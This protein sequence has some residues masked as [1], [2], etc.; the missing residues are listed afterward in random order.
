MS[1]SMVE[2]ELFVAPNKVPR[3]PLPVFHFDHCLIFAEKLRVS[4]M[5]IDETPVLRQKG[6]TI[7]HESTHD[8]TVISFAEHLQPTQ[9]SIRRCASLFLSTTITCA[10]PVARDRFPF[11]RIIPS[12]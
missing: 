9:S 1:G 6:G 2:L 10:R 8:S 7:H 12:S 11:F 3:I 5:P 4:L